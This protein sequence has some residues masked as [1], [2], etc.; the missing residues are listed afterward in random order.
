[1]GDGSVSGLSITCTLPDRDGDCKGISAFFPARVPAASGG[2]APLAGPAFGQV[3][4]LV[5]NLAVD[6]CGPM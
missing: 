2:W 6:R 3:S 1:M 5:T 4:L